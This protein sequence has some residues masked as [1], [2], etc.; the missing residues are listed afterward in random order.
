MERVRAQYPEEI[1]NEE[2]AALK[3]VIENQEVEI[4]QLEAEVETLKAKAAKQTT[5]KKKEAEE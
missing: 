5:R 3:Q 2:L 4:V 1:D